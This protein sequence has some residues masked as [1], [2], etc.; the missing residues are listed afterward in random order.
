MSKFKV[1]S[2]L[3]SSPSCHPKKRN[4]RSEF[5]LA[6]TLSAAFSHSATKPCAD[7]LPRKLNQT[8]AICGNLAAQFAQQGIMSPKMS[9]AT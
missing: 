9:F 3:P 8:N 4:H 7:S 1:R 6:N 2:W 5:F